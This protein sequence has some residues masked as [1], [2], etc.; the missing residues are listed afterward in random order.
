VRRH[1]EVQAEHAAAMLELFADLP[2]L[3][4]RSVARDRNVRTREAL[5]LG[6]EAL[7]EFEVFRCG[8]NDHADAAPVDCVEACVGLY[9]ARVRGIAAELRQAGVDAARNGIACL[10][11]RAHDVDVPAIRGVDDRDVPAH[12]SAADDDDAR[13]IL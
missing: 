7:L 9:P 6:E 12:D 1:E 8:L 13:S 3:E 5:D 4:I 2:D 10:G 11:R